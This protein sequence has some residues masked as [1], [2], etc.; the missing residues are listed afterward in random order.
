MRGGKYKTINKTDHLPWN[1]H[2]WGEDR[3]YTHIYRNKYII[4]NCGKGLEGKLH[5]V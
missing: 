4:I 5:A 1:L 3:H 2:S